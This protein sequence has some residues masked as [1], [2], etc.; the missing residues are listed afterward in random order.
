MSDEH[1]GPAMRAL[2]PMQRRFVLAILADPFGNGARWARAAG[3]SD[4]SEAAKVTAHRLLHDPKVEA[5]IAE[6][7]R[8]QLNVLGPVLAT[9]GLIR[10]ARNAKHPKHFQ[11]LEALANRTGFHETSEHRV[12]VHHTDRTGVAMAERIRALAVQLGMDPAALLGANAPAEPMKLI[13]GEATEVI[14]GPPDRL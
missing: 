5:A 1:F 4:A 7:T 14:D 3:Y 10:I 2:G 11:A 12:S 6:M 9:A 13:E 8:E